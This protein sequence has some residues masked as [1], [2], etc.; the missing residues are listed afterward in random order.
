MKGWFFSDF[1]EQERKWSSSPLHFWTPSLFPYFQ[2]RFYKG[3]WD[4]RKPNWPLDP[5]KWLTCSKSVKTCVSSAK[6]SFIP[7]KYTMTSSLSLPYFCLL[8]FSLPAFWPSVA[9]R[10]AKKMLQD[11]IVYDVMMF[12]CCCPWE[13]RMLGTLEDQLYWLYFI[14]RRSIR[15]HFKTPWEYAAEA[16]WQW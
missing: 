7:A 15:F 11:L 1:K 16:L 3:S 9:F 10:T 5:L 4:Q 14:N 12:F 6:C 2:W 8:D 13:Q